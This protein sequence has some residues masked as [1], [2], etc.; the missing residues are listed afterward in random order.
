MKMYN[1]DAIQEEVNLRKRL[2]DMWILFSAHQEDPIKFHLTPEAMHYYNEWCVKNNDILAKM[3]DDPKLSMF[4]RLQIHTLKLAMLFTI[5]RFGSLEE[6]DTGNITI[7][8]EHVYEAIRVIE[9]YF[10]PIAWKIYEMV[11]LAESE[12]DQKKILSALKQRGGK[13]SRRMLMRKVRMK[14]K[15]LDDAIHQLVNETKEL[16]EVEV[17]GQRGGST[18]Y[19]IM[20]KPEE[21]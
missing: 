3:S 1:P 7:T 16:M 6:L 19:Y 4:A 8:N 15:D 13:I 17:K 14:S 5:G 9:T 20:T 12:N 11:E 10:M 18:I 2:L 21:S